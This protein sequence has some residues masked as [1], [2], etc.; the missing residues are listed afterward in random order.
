M[1]QNFGFG[2]YEGITG[3]VTRPMEGHK[4]EGAVGLLK[5]VGQ[6]SVELFTKPG[7]GKQHPSAM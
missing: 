7:S 5:G 6:G 3:M 4:K 1:S 2:F